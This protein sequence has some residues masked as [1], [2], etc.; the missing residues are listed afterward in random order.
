MKTDAQIDAALERLDNCPRDFEGLSYKGGIIDG[1]N[2]V[3]E[4]ITDEEFEF[5]PS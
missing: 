4:I 5:G 1:L 3:L 2:W